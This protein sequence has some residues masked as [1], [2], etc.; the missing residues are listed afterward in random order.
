MLKQYEGGKRRGA[1]VDFEDLVAT[2]CEL[3][4]RP[5]VAAWVL[6]KLDGGLDHILIDEAQDT[7]PEQWDVVRAL[8]EEF[9]SGEGAYEEVR[10]AGRSIFAVGDV[11]QS[12]FSFQRADPEGFLRMRRHFAARV[13]TASKSWASV[14]LEVSFRSGAAVLGLVDRLLNSRGCAGGR[15]GW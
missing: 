11:K 1:L 10:G 15:C 8:T 3:L 6:F 4:R 5:G 9:F 7:N 13:E 12:I 14:D 2:V